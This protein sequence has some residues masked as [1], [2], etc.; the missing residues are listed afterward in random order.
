[1]R[2]TIIITIPI[3]FGIFE[4]IVVRP[5][6]SKLVVLE[7][8]ELKPPKI[9][10]LLFSNDTMNTPKNSIITEI[11]NIPNAFLNIPLVLNHQSYQSVCSAA[12]AR[13]R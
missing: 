4:L 3:K 9:N 7:V 2:K 11:K 5:A 13:S 10:S 12:F 8:V 6:M 1:M